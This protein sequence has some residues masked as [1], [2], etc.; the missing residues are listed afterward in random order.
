MLLYTLWVAKRTL[1]NDPVPNVT[2]TS[3]SSND[4]G[5]G[6]FLT[7]VVIIDVNTNT[8]N[9][10]NLNTNQYIYKEK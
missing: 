7:S 4:N 8:N 5:V 3:K 1:P 10:N 9:N 6:N 2:P